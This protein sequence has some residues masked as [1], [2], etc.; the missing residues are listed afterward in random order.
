[1]SF[2][3]LNTPQNVRSSVR[4][5][6]RVTISATGRTDTLFP[7]DFLLS[8]ESP[9]HSIP[10]RVVRTPYCHR[11]PLRTVHDQSTLYTI[12]RT[13]GLSRQPHFAYGLALWS[14]VPAIPIGPEE[15][16]GYRYVRTLRA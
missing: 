7:R 12:R 8:P 4:V 5:A 16:V 1:M 6:S 3:F 2:R 9:R 14:F 13:T 10:E 11:L 15:R